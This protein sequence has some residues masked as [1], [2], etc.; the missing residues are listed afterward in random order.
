MEPFV[1]G[2]GVEPQSAAADMNHGFKLPEL[3][4]ILFRIDFY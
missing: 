1:A 3:Y 4:N 2:W